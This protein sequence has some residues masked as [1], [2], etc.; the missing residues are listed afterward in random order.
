LVGVR[1]LG[2]WSSDL[3]GGAGC[4]TWDFS[5]P[6]TSVVGR[7]NPWYFEEGLPAHFFEFHL[8]LDDLPPACSRGSKLMETRAALNPFEG[9]SLCLFRS[10]NPRR[11]SRHLCKSRLNLG[12]S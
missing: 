5:H 1:E 12:R 9:R 11:R 7:E 6:L 3:V 10:R 4:A 2:R 8:V